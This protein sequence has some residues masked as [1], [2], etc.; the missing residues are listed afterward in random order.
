MEVEKNGVTARYPSLCPVCSAPIAV[1]DRI[2][3]RRPH[4]WVCS[5]CA[6][7]LESQPPTAAEVLTNLAHSCAQQT[8]GGDAV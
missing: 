6:R 5:T 4:G 2:Y 1:G 8:A 3:P 7:V